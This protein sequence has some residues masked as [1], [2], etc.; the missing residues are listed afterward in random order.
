MFK[1]LQSNCQVVIN[2]INEKE[3]EEEENHPNCIL[4]EDSKVIRIKINVKIVHILREAN[5]CADIL[6]KLGSE[7]ND[8]EIRLLVPP[9]E[10]IEEMYCNLRGVAYTR[11]T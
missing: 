11:G 5:R 4:I 9:N 7:Q 3:E 8:Q 1:D 6:A 10:I 2:L